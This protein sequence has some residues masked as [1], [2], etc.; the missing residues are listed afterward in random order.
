VP[1]KRSARPELVD[2]VALAIRT[3]GAWWQGRPEVPREQ[4]VDAIVDLAAA[5]AHRIAAER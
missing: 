3:Y 2:L 1:A 4:V 5:G